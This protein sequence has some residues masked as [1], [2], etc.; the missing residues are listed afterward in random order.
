MELLYF[1]TRGDHHRIDANNVGF[2][3]VVPVENFYLYRDPCT[4]AC[5]H[6]LG[7]WEIG[8]RY[9]RV[10]IE[11]GLVQVLDKGGEL[12]SI[13]VGLNWYLNPNTK[14][15]LNYVYTTGLFGNLGLTH[16]EF[17]SLGTRVHFDF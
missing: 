14:I 2:D 1:L 8:I 15:M 13:T 12:D 11:D 16:G 6:G 7:A 10:N 5:G 4:G 9:D 3:R 17:Q